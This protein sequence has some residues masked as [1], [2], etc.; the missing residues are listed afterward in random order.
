MNNKKKFVL[1]AISP[2]I[3]AF[4]IFILFFISVFLFGDSPSTEEIH[5]VLIA[6]FLVPLIAEIIFIIPALIVAYVFYK[7]NSMFISGISAFAICF[8]PAIFLTKYHSE[9]FLGNT[10][11]F[12]FFGITAMIVTF[13]V[14]KVLEKKR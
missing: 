7:S 14:C 9:D 3:A 4:V 12:L 5:T 11:V 10:L 2:L 1:F 6:M 13:V 8:S